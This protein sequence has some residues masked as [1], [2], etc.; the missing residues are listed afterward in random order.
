[1]AEQILLFLAIARQSVETA[2]VMVLVPGH[3][4]V[5]DYTVDIALLQNGVMYPR[6]IPLIL[7]RIWFVAHCHHLSALI[8][9][10]MHLL[11]VCP[12]TVEL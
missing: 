5:G 7:L 3:S 8:K 9:S 4:M 2:V 12:V 10:F 11:C 6:V 1:M